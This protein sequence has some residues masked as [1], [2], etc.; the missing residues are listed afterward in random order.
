LITS[1]NQS[2]LLANQKQGA[3]VR[4]YYY[5]SS[6]TSAK[7]LG[8]NHLVEWNQ[9]LLT[10]LHLILMC[11]IT[12]WAHLG[13]FYRAINYQTKTLETLCTYSLSQST[14][15][16]GICGPNIQPY[17]FETSTTL[18]RPTSVMAPYLH[19]SGQISHLSR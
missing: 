18:N 6:T 12:Y 13:T 10:F 17:P 2:L 11:T 7:M 9:H 4:S 15:T 1:S 3:I 8:Q 19:I 5:T 16:L 14:C